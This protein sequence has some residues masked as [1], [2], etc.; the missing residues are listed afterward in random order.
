MLMANALDPKCID[1]QK[2]K[3]QMQ[4]SLLIVRV[5]TW[6]KISSFTHTFSCSSP[7]L[8]YKCTTT[9]RK[10][11]WSSDCIFATL[12]FYQMQRVVEMKSRISEM[13]KQQR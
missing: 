1:R 4:V 11:M 7:N 13:S 2:V 6:I 3:K 8:I 9:D 5:W 12:K 10:C